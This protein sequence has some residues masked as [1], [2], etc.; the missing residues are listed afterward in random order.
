[1]P[2]QAFGQQFSGD[3]HGD[4]LAAFVASHEVNSVGLLNLSEGK[5]TTDPRP[6][7]DPT[8]PEYMGR[9]KDLRERRFRALHNAPR[10]MVEQAAMNDEINRSR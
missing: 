9:G 6:P 8:H 2:V 1:M 5:K 7:Y 3:G 10:W 4:A